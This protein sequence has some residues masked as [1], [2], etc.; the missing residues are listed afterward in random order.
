MKKTFIIAVSGGVDSVVLLHKLVSV[1]H[2]NINYIVAHFDHGIRP[3]SNADAEFVEQIA[4]NSQLAFELGEGNLGKNSSEDE[5]R[6]ARYNFLFTVMQKYKA[7]GIITAHHRDDVIET[8]VVN[9]LRGTSPRGLMGF[10]RAEIIRPFIDKTKADLI[11]YAHE[12]KL[13]WHEDSTNSDPKYL[14]NY[15][16]QN[17]I[18]KLS[19]KQSTE[20][21]KIREK[22]VDIYRE[23]DALDK[24]ILV[25]CMKKSELVRSRFVVLPVKVQMEILSTWFR[26]NNVAFDSKLLEKAAN[27]I[28]VFKPG[29]VFELT[30]NKKLII[31]RLR[32][33]LQID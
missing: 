10:S 30:S 4:K 21:L 32:I 12:H 2:P 19:A 8:M 27:A 9:I 15:I 6:R 13:T 28:K 3:D 1:K 17:I 5:A 20:L 22:L 31:G 24:K 7:D 16:R 11:K 25:Q 18:P 14:R 26:L 29:K 23:V 33:N